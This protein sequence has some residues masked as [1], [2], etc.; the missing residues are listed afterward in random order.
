MLNDAALL[1]TIMFVVTEVRSLFLRVL[2]TLVLELS[3]LRVCGIAPF[4]LTGGGANNNK[5]DF[6]RT[7]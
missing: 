1:E 6:L 5:S 2:K 3:M 4:V 7:K